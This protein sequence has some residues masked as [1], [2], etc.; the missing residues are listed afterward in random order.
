MNK[1]NYRKII[2][3]INSTLYSVQNKAFQW[4]VVDENDNVVV[5]FGKYKWID[6]FQN[7]LA[8]VKGHNDT[9]SNPN[10][11][12]MSFSA[13]DIDSSIPK[14]KR[15]AAQGIIN[16]KGEMVLPL[17][18]TVWKFY[19]KDFPTIK[20]F[21][22]D[23][24]FEIP[25]EKLNPDLVEEYDD[26]NFDTD[27]DDSPNYRNLMEDSWNAMTDGQYGD[28]PEDFDGDYSFLGY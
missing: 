8:K 10:N 25:F 16:E 7:G 27:Y 2:Q 26:H 15:I 9:T 21:K 28:M 23:M 4:G 19:G 22:E 20:V 1:E 3:P 11:V 17:E 24:K 13:S 6:G 18:Y 12:I 14:P 5:E